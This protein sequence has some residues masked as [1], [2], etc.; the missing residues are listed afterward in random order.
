MFDI[1]FLYYIF[2]DFDTFI[3]IDK[4]ALYTYFSQTP[5]KHFSKPEYAQS[6]SLSSHFKLTVSIVD[7]IDLF[8]LFSLPV[9]LRQ[10]N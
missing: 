5:L 8:S 4:C 6:I 9:F 2:L 10:Y 1:L 7:I 3:Y